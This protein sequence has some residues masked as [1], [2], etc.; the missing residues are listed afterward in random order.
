MTIDVITQ[1]LQWKESRNSLRLVTG[2]VGGIGYGLVIV[3]II[4]F[5]KGLLVRI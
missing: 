5:I 3:M 4:I 1:S 2:L